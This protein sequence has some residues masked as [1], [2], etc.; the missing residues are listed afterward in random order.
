MFWI[1]HPFLF[2]FIMKLN[3]LNYLSLQC[4]YCRKLYKLCW[5]HQESNSA[6]TCL[7]VTSLAYQSFNLIFLLVSFFPLAEKLSK[8]HKSILKLNRFVTHKIW[9]CLS[10]IIFLWYKSFISVLMQ[11]WGDPK[12]NSQWENEKGIQ[13][14]FLC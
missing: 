14:A 8:K 5:I 13:T 2:D 10:L 1:I 9:I 12:R 7:N 6:V 3:I 11:Y 4:S